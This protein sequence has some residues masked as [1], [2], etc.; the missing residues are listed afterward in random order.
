MIRFDELRTDMTTGLLKFNGQI[1]RETRLIT[2]GSYLQAFRDDSQWVDPYDEKSVE[3]VYGQTQSGW[4]IYELKP[5][6]LVLCSSAETIT[7]DKNHFGLLSTLSHAARF[8]LM[9]TPSSF[10]VDPGFSGHVTLELVNLSP[11]S[12]RIREAMP[13]AKL[14]VLKC[15]TAWPEDTLESNSAISHYGKAADMSSKF[16]LEF[17]PPQKGL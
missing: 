5:R 11:I 2:L 14:V 9:S 6:E 4:D 15:D 8:G 10:F 7:F 1:R 16:Y 13:V 17:Q 3:A 12:I